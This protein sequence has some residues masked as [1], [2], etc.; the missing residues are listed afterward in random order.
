MKKFLTLIT[1]IIILTLALS[2]CSTSVKP[3]ANV[4]GD[5]VKSTNG[6]FAVEKGN[7][8]YFVNGVGDMKGNN[9]MGEVEKG[10]LV[11]V[12]TSEIGKTSQT[13]ETVIP[14]LVTTASATNG[15]FIYGNT[16]YYASPYDE[17]DKTSTVRNDY[18]D[19]R[20]FDL[21]TAKSNRITYENDTVNSYRFIES[22]SDVF[23]VYETNETVDGT[24]TNVFKVFNAKTG[25]EVYSVNGYSQIF[26]ADDN[27]KNVFFVKLAHSDELD[28][29]EAFSEVYLYTVGSTSHSLVYSGCGTNGLTRDGRGKDANYKSKILPYSDISGVTVSL[30]KN[31]GSVLVFKVTGIDT[32]YP[33]VYYYGVN[34]VDGS[35]ALKQTYAISDLIELGKSDAFID[36]ALT[37]NSYFKSLSEVYYVENSTYLKGLVKFDYNNLNKADHGRTLLTSDA[38]G[39]NI[40]MVDGGYIYLVSTDGFY[41][42][43]K[44]DG[45]ETSLRKINAVAAKGVTDWHK[46][47]VINGNFV[48]VYSSE[49]FYNYV[50]SVDMTDIDKDS[51]EEKLEDYESLDR[52]KVETIKGTLLG[53]MTQTDEDAYQTKLDNDYPEED[54]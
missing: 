29:D 27:S 20:S 31:T 47:R 45:S 23:L 12:K 14:K 46:P 49:I 13:I 36:A 42:R 15:V 21:T 4:E 43:I 33:T 41:Y 3:L 37:S 22:G 38:N 40:S 1:A 8:V 34:L 6:T 25:A 50:Y 35:G 53:K 10:A 5:V 2:G 24:A 26:V 19:F 48:C 52:E 17:K 51:Y 18:T 28:E 39:Y 30:I 54:E 7:Y 16:V 11:R 44:L 9:E 32:N